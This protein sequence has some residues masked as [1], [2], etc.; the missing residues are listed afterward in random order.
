M[1][2]DWGSTGNSIDRVSF[3]SPVCLWGA[4]GRGV[5]SH[6]NLKALGFFPVFLRPDG[7]VLLNVVFLIWNI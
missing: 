3:P 1:L 5:G 7:K 6:L 2:N 4:G